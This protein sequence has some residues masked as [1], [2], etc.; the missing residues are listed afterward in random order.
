MRLQERRFCAMIALY[1][2]EEGSAMFGFTT[3]S[4]HKSRMVALLLCFFFG[5]A[6]IHHLYVGRYGMWI[7]YMMTLGFFGIGW[8]WNLFQ[9]LIGSYRDRYGHYLI[10]W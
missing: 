10:R 2:N 4:S 7:L 1:S 9:I 3:P 5:F 6:G 8:I